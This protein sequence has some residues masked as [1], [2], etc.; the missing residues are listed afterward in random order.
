MEAESAIILVETK[1]GKV[2]QVNINT[3]EVMK[4]LE[5]YYS[6]RGWIPIIGK[7][8]EGIQI[9]KIVNAT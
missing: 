2:Y 9:G 1:E 3:D 6:K 7:P 8:I 5:Q 4:Y